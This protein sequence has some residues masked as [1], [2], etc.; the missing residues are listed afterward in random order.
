MENINSGLL[1]ALLAADDDVKPEAGSCPMPKTTFPEDMPYAMAYV[2]FQRWQKTYDD[3]AGLERG[4][5]FPCLDKPFIGE[6]AVKH[7]K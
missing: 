3:E 2:P 1:G 6:E 5:V 4:T 7:D